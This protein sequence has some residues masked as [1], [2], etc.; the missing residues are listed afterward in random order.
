VNEPVIIEVTRRADNKLYPARP[1]TR[2]QRNRARWLAH[3][4]VHRDGLSIRAAQRAMLAR[5][6]R[7]SLGIIARDLA[8]YE[9]PACAGG[10]PARQQ[11][12]RQQQ[13]WPG[14]GWAGH[15]PWYGQGRVTQPPGAVP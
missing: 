11:A 9:C 15:A 3:N 2:E 1:L 10:P 12:G 13:D 7:R 6:V 4:L 8:S 5:G 14:G